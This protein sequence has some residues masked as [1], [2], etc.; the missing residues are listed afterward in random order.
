MIIE[1]QQAAHKAATEILNA[2]EKQDDRF[3]Y[4]LLTTHEG[5]T[6]STHSS[7]TSPSVLSRMLATCL[8]AKDLAAALSLTLEK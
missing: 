6:V 5:S 2:A 4:V 1:S 8:Q 3:H 7:N